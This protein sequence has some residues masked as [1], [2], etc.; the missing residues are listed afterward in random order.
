MSSRPRVALV[1]GGARGEIISTFLHDCSAA[2]QIDLPVQAYEFQP[3]YLTIN[4]QEFRSNSRWSALQASLISN[5]V[6]VGIIA[7]LRSI[8]PPEVLQEPSHGFINLHAGPVPEYRGGSVLNWQL[9]QGEEH[10]GVS[11]LIVTPE[12]DDGPVIASAN[13]PIKPTATIADLHTEANRLFVSLLSDFL[14]DP[15]NQLS[16]AKTQTGPATYWHQRS[17]ADGQLLPAFQSASL[18]ERIVRALASP[19]P[20]AWVRSG[21]ATTRILRVEPAKPSYRGTP[22]RVV[23]LPGRDPLIIFR[24]GALSVLA[25]QDEQGIGLRNGDRICSY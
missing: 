7:G 15:V 13:F 17:D 6:T 19:Y 11:L 23:H 2:G 12:L 1:G 4:R 10:A 3:G 16:R 9:I 18:A 8:L 5:E 21:Y 24:Q 22:G 20:G 14:S 25:W